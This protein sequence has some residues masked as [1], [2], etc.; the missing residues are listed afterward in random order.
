MTEPVRV[1][2]IID[3]LE[4]GGSQRWLWEIVRRAEPGIAHH[5]ITSIPDAGTRPYTYADRLRSAGAYDQRPAG[6]LARRVEAL[7]HGPRA[8]P[9]G[10]LR[11]RLAGLIWLWLSSVA[12]IGEARRVTRSFRPTVIHTHTYFGYVIGLAI[13]AWTRKK[14]VHTVPALASQMAEARGSWLPW[15]YGRTY[16][17]V[18]RFFTNMGSE[19]RA[20]GVPPDRLFEIPGMV[21]LDE[22]D[23]V[24]AERPR[25]RADVRRM[26]GIEGGAPL[27][28][29]VGRLHRT[30]GHA[31][32]LESMS[33]VASEDAHLV[34][35]GEGALHGHLVASAAELGLRDRVHLVGFREDALVFY[36]AADVYLRLGLLEGDNMSSYVAIAMGLPVVAFD[37]GA[38]TDL[39]PTVG[40]G[41]LVPNGDT[42]QAAL[43]VDRI[44]TDPER[45]RQLG[46]RGAA[47]ARDHLDLRTTIT[48]YQRF[49][50]ELSHR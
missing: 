20:V 22:I 3:T 34:I 24:T 8:L 40:H 50:R 7:L 41:I 29:S 4:G 5:V 18:D 21:D 36:A 1:L 17:L 28:L 25:H 43:A 44:L 37:T 47:F 11:R 39:V 30:K 46:A 48:A 2:H 49:Y 26:L 10:T 23:A 13:R 15:L 32:A 42:V 35:L 38:E 33:R 19:Q 12:V 6:R 45:A 27:L 9:T 14:L 16:A 31:E